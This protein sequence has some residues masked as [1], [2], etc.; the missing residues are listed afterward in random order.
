MKLFGKR[1]LLFLLPPVIIILCAD[2]FLRSQNNMYKEKYNGALENKDSIEILILGNSHATYGVD[3]TV[4]NK[5]AYNIANVNQS[6]YFDKRITLPLMKDL[7]KLK[8]VLI[9][10]DFHSLY[11]SSQ[12][13][14]DIWSY[15]GNGIKYKDK[16][17]LLADISPS[18]FGYT[19]KVAV[20]LIKKRIL[21]A[22]KYRDEK[23][24][25]FD[26]EKGINL[27][28]TIKKGFVSFESTKENSFTV[29]EFR[30]K[31]EGY[32]G[33]I[34]NDKIRD[35]VVKDL[36][37]FI[38]KLIANGVTPILFTSPVYKDYYT[39]LDSTAIRENET[40]L[41]KISKKYNIKYWDFSNLSV[42]TKD[43]FY[44]SDH[45]NKKGAA[46]FSAVLNDSLQVH[47]TDIALLNRF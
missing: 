41:M 26:V 34:K 14:R 18:I 36:E 7:T 22:I 45:L 32:N 13:I 38:Q 10:V 28:D 46:K 16:D 23:V 37:D 5:Y 17:Y 35:E 27:K 44:N 4:L 12:G 30:K 21:R 19:P 3:P 1:I 2:I 11:F 9:S 25:D 33:M 42:M 20:S 31:A 24:I 6:I 39:F 29:D 47:D 8:Y 43:D 15:Y 40:L